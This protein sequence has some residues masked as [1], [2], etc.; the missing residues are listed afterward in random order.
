MEDWKNSEDNSIN[1]TEVTGFNSNHLSPIQTNEYP[2]EESPGN[3]HKTFL[4]LSSHNSNL[5]TLLQ[6]W[7]L[8]HLYQHLHC[9]YTNSLYR[10]QGR[11]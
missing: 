11:R 2:N 3:S 10:S 8:E 1:L 7:D 6:A 9:K 5:L 4:E